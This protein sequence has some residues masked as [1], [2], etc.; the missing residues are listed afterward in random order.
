MSGYQLSRKAYDLHFKW[1]NKIKGWKVLE[2]FS[3]GLDLN[4]IET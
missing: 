1:L 4:V 3:P 2:C